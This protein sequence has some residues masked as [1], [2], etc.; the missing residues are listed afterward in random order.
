[1]SNAQSAVIS[2]PELLGLTLSYLPVRD[3]LVAAPLVSKTWQ[4]LTLTPALQR[5]LFF[6]P[7]PASEYVQ[8][9]LLAEVFLPFFGRRSRDLWSWPNTKAIKS[10]PWSKAPEAFRRPEASWRRMLVTQPPIQMMI[11]TE[12]CQGR[13]SVRGRRAEL[14]DLSLRMGYLYDLTIPLVNR[15]ACWF[16]VR[17]VH[18]DNRGAEL[19]LTV[20]YM[21]QCTLGTTRVLD[22]AFYS[23]ASKYIP[24]GFGPWGDPPSRS[25]SPSPELRLALSDEESGEGSDEEPDEESD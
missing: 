4:A 14:N 17:C 16:F 21:Q 3:L 23:D 8:N 20:V 6:Q 5:A 25:R 24:I 15:V 10:M 7:N 22:K 1:M 11:I 12:T 9:P 18:D 19:T 2:I 13:G